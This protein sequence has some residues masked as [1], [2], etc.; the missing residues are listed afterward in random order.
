MIQNIVYQNYMINKKQ[1]KSTILMNYLSS[2]SNHERFKNRHR[3]N[4]AVKNINDE[5]EDAEKKFDKLFKY[6]E[7]DYYL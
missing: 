3:I 7:K 5:L 2:L 1:N 6:D 4:Q